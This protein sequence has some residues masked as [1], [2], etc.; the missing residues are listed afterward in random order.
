MKNDN[1]LNSLAVIDRLEVGP[2]RLECNRLIAPYTVFRDEQEFTTDLLYRYEENVFDP[3]EA[4]SRNLANM[5]AVQV[6][7]NYGLFCKTIVF[8]GELDSADQ[9]FIKGM[10]EN[11]AREIYVNKFL[12]NN[13]FL[14]GDAKQLPIVKQRSYLQ[15]EL[16]F[17]GTDD[18]G[19]HQSFAP[20][21]TDAA[22][23]A[24][25]S[26]G[27]KD[28]L[29]SFGLLNELAVEVHALFGNESGRHWFTALNAH[30]YFREVY[31]NTARVWMNSDRL[32][33]WMLRHFSFVR[34]DFANIRADIYPIRLWTVAVFLFGVL[35]L[36]RK[37]GIGRL[38]I[39]D[40][41]DS[42][43]RRRY[44]DIPHYDG[45]YDQSRYFD[46]TLTAYFKRKGWQILQFSALRQ[47]SEMLILKI[48]VQRYPELQ[49]HQ[50]S[51]HASHKAGDRIHPCGK[52]EKCRRIVGML[53]AFDA[54]PQHCGYSELQIA[55][56]LKDIPAK[57]LHLE[58]AGERHI[59]AVLSGKGLLKLPE[60]HRKPPAAAPEILN[61]RFHPERSPQETIPEDIRNRLFKLYLAHAEG[62]VIRDGNTW[63]PFDPFS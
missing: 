43:C 10:A 49:A 58:A 52:C 59:L 18:S 50:I 1:P 54:D 51:C 62:A 46:N 16:I 63:K 37:R 28:S 61:L 8:S 34:Q 22:R 41:H 4:E 27:G 38:L 24:V 31:P 17:Q 26:S 35:P 20:W 47:L 13:P 2:V 19:R 23:Y 14:L 60:R 44:N 55:N 6:A 32:F 11:T 48:L 3:N 7:I 39:G 30:R 57:G 25:L 56:C 5:I 53:L 33:N 15:A 36:M 45:L 40:E 12:I 9:R 29:L 42:T 21:K